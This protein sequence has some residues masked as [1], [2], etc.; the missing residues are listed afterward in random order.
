VETFFSEL[1]RH[2]LQRGAFTSV[3][4]LEAAIYDDIQEHNDDPKPF[5][6]TA[7]PDRILASMSRVN[8]PSESLH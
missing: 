7:D 1:T 5:V 3:K 6:W 8:L 2:S 4:D